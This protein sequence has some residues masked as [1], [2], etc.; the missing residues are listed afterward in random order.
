MKN[1]TRLCRV[2][3]LALSGST[4]YLSAHEQA[5]LSRSLDVTD[6]KT[7]PGELPD[8]YTFAQVQSLLGE[9]N[10]DSA[11]VWWNV[12]QRAADPSTLSRQPA[13]PSENQPAI[14]GS[15]RVFRALPVSFNISPQ[16]SQ[17][18][19]KDSPGHLRWLRY[20]QDKISRNPAEVLAIVTEEVTG[21]PNDVCEIVKLAIQASSADV[22]VTAKIVEAAVMAQPASMRLAAQ[23]AMAVMP[24]A[25]AE[26]QAVLAKLDPAGASGSSDK[27]AKDAK[28]AKFGEVASVISPNPL[29]I[30]GVVPPGIP[31]II[32]P[33]E[34]PPEE[35]PPVTD[36]SFIPPGQDETP[37]RDS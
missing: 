10:Y 18:A 29:D 8:V 13:E 23:C 12:N 16:P 14:S 36:V 24:D 32:P 26:I 20:L 4:A 22:T 37:G 5:G 30:P 6:I 31:D 17:P 27:D 28:D 15:P 9:P 11:P 1:T 2:L 33:P 19:H 35:I 34:I 21:H 7:I 25:L 3:A